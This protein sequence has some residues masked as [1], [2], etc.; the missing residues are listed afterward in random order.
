MRL[1]NININPKQYL[2]I[3]LTA[4]YGV[5]RKTSVKICNEC[6]ISPTAKAISLTKEEQEKM[7][8]VLKNYMIEGDLRRKVNGDIRRLVDIQAY[9]GRRHRAGLPVRGQRT[10]S[11]AKTARKKG[12]FNL[13]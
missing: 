2:E 12:K 10:S 9:R 8:D 13:K 4:I 1:A 6:N 3:S 7:R 11:N 5:G